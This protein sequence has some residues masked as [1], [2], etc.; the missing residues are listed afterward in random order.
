MVNAAT[1]TETDEGETY[2]LKLNNALD[3][4]ESMDK[5]LLCTKQ[6]CHNSIVV[7]DFPPAIDYNKTS[8]FSIYF[9]NENKRFPLHIINELSTIGF[10]RWVCSM[11]NIIP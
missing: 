5:S 9:L 2:I 10:D 1:A 11:G 6:A 3:F 4:R 8:T 7:Y